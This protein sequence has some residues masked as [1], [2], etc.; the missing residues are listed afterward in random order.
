MKHNQM[1][2]HDG[3][4]TVRRAADWAGI[5]LTAG[6]LALLGDLADWLVAEAIP[7]GGLGPAEGPVV[8]SRH[9]ADSL[10]FATP[11]RSRPGSPATILDIGA[12]VGLP[13]LPLAICWP[14]SRVTLLERSARRS[15]LAKRAVRLLGLENVEVATTQM[16]EWETTAELLV[17]RAVSSP[18]RLRGDL[19]RLL[20]PSGVAVIGGS[21]HTLPNYQGFSTCRIPSNILGNP[22][23]LLIMDKT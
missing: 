9:L 10:L 6:Q 22:V 14:S 11:W 8:H 5:S 1:A 2:G 19:R 23:W 13:G 15:D 12:G 17:C 4:N 18:N 20:D 16:R 3:M 21:H 7:A